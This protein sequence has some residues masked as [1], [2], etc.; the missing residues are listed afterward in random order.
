MLTNRLTIDVVVACGN[1]GSINLEG[2][3]RQTTLQPLL[4][5]GKHDTDRTSSGVFSARR[6]PLDEQV[7][8][9]G[10]STSRRR[11][12]A[13]VMV[14]STSEGKSPRTSASR[15]A[16]RHGVSRGLDAGAKGCPVSEK[17]GPFSEEFAREGLSRGARVPGTRSGWANRAQLA[18]PAPRPP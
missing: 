4:Q 16:T 3:G 6:T 7:P 12:R 18:R 14:L 5:E 13:E 15:P 1:S 8:L 2:G 17:E 9:Q 11:A 10:V